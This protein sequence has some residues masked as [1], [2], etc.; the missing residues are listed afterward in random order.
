MG[1]SKLTIE[2]VCL[3]VHADLFQAGQMAN[4]AFMFVWSGFDMLGVRI[5][6]TTRLAMLPSKPD[7]HGIER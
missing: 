1:I 2:A 7:I 4:G 3:F 6:R 5:G